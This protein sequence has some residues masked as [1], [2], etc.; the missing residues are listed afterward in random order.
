MS[1]VSYGII[2]HTGDTAK[3]VLSLSTKKIGVFSAYIYIDNVANPFDRKYI[4]VSIEVVMDPTT[5]LQAP[6][7]RDTEWF[8]VLIP[9]WF[10][11]VD[12]GKLVVKWW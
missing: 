2:D 4:R 9:E 3:V 5:A 12:V 6:G 7:D 8:S 11:S 10:A 1:H